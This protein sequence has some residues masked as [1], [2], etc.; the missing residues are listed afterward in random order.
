[1]TGVS[2]SIL[3][4]THPGRKL[5]WV[6]YA[7]TIV[8][9]LIAVLTLIEY[10]TGWMMGLD[11]LLFYD[12]ETPS[13]LFPG[14]MSLGTAFCFFLGG[15]TLLLLATGHNLAAQIFATIMGFTALLALIGYVYN[16]NSLYRVFIYSS[17][18]LHTS[19]AF[20]LLS[21]GLLLARPAQGL[22]TV[23][24][25]DTVG[26]MMARRLLP[27]AIILP[28]ALGIAI[29]IGQTWG[30][31]DA[32]FGTSLLIL[33]TTV[34]LCVVIFWNTH[35][36]YTIDR[37]RQHTLEALEQ[38]E[39]KYRTIFENAM[40]GIYQCLPSGR[41]IT[42]N[43]AMA[44]MLHYESPTNLIANLTNIEQQLFAG[45]QQYAEFM[46]QFAER[47]FVEEFEA[48]LL[49][50][51]GRK[52]WG[53]MNMHGAQDNNGQLLHYEGTIVNISKRKQAEEERTKLETQLQQA[54]KMESIG[55]LA[56]GIAHDFNN[57][58][59]P[60]IGYTD[61]NLM[62]LSP[63]SK[64]YA[65]LKRIRKAADRAAN[66]T[67][68]ILAFSRQQML[69][70]HVLD[71]NVVI[72]AF[73]EMLQYMLREDIELRLSLTPTL[74]RIKA[75]QGQIE[76]VLM[77]LVVN[78]SDAMPD[79]GK[80][81]IETANVFLDERYAAKYLDIQPGPHVMLAISDN[82][83]G[84]D[85]ETQ[86]RIFEPFFTTKGVDKGTGLGLATVFGIIKQHQGHIWVYSEPGSGT[87]FKIYI[88]Q[89]TDLTPV[90]DPVIEEPLS[91]YYGTET[92]LVAEDDEM[93]RKLV[94]ETLEAYGYSVIEASDPAHALQLVATYKDSIHLLVT[95]VI[96]PKMSGRELYQKFV[97]V[98][99][100]SSVLYMSGYTDS[101]VVHHN[102]L[103][104]AAN[105][106]Q[107]PFTIHSL[108]QKVTKALNQD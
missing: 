46:K 108:M 22:M 52:I 90:G 31:Y 44:Q 66:L 82:G 83:Q 99:A 33:S 14:R 41:I 84:I 63:E 71:L 23:I 16:V 17:M 91:E 78:A 10:L 92:V 51:D 67:R 100:N 8:M 58:L 64:L 62:N 68:Q 2:L 4:K 80:L 24:T 104:E 72:S 42:V 3:G 75:D 60:I 12:F 79:G 55:R 29:M 69:D 96:M 32:N 25:S 30:N 81:I 97:G 88:P 48:Q 89:S 65:D 56:G 86:K 101:V 85:A 102:I 49:C 28:M 21:W 103:D 39:E 106:L 57:L 5:R 47:G 107:K 19:A 94:C 76:Q 11:Q 40:E 6:G 13:A 70:M 18:A 77:N 20:F 38:A 34:I 35:A 54:Q 74:Y 95:D 45:P 15:S 59:M 27:V 87:T 9:T 93:V 50:R 98:H 43:R 7:C 1:L 61:L 53:V 26:G 37:E 73:R 36:L 105:F